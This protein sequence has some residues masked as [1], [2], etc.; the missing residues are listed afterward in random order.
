MEGEPVDQS[1]SE[2]ETDF[3]SSPQ[4]T[5][6]SSSGDDSDIDR[7]SGGTNGTRFSTDYRHQLVSA[8]KRRFVRPEQDSKNSSNIHAQNSHIDDSMNSDIYHQ[9]EQS[10]YQEPSYE[11]QHEQQH[12]QENRHDNH[13]NGHNARSPMK[14]RQQPTA[15]HHGI[16]QEQQHNH[17]SDDDEQQYPVLDPFEGRVM[18]MDDSAVVNSRATRIA[19]TESAIRQ[20]MFKECTFKP[21]IT[22]LPRSYGSSSGKE[23]TPFYTRVM[24]WQKDRDND[25]KRRLDNHKENNKTDCTFNPQINRHSERAAAQNRA[26]S[27]K[28]SSENVNK[29]TANERLYKST[30]LAKQHKEYVADEITREKDEKQRQE[31]EYRI[32][33]SNN[34]KYSEV[35]PRV[36]DNLLDNNPNNNNTSMIGNNTTNNSNMN[37]NTTQQTPRRGATPSKDPNCSFTPKVKGVSNQ[38]TSAKLYL[39]A[40]VVDRLTK[41]IVQNQ[42]RSYDDNYIHNTNLRRSGSGANTTTN[43]NGLGDG[44]SDVMDVASFMSSLGGNMPYNTPG[45]KPTPNNNNNTNGHGNRPQSAPRER[46]VSDNASVNSQYSN[47]TM[48][49]NTNT[50]TNA[51]NNDKKV[52][53][54]K[55]KQFLERQRQSL[56]KKTHNIQDVS[57]YMYI[58]MTVCI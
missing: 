7:R 16:V 36:Y 26:Q 54:D 8:L 53:M 35:A 51:S 46:G 47:N 58:Y 15:Y 44:R 5:G 22:K 27:T 24:R 52:R 32:H 30:L 41:P 33:G 45:Y 40:N 17:N 3:S 50:N 13:D 28:H 2:F 37:Q 34:P 14:S 48:I 25:A 56:K 31:N 9:P 49:S 6:L 10:S 11:Q 18:T 1:Q 42:K 55:F 43:N 39:S 20:D 19:Q 57:I 29:I 12:N 23:N 21:V 38:M 4:D